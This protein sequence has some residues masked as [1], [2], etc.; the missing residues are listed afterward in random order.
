MKGLLENDDK[1]K[2]C[3][4]AQPIRFCKL[5]SSQVKMEDKPKTPANTQADSRSQ[6][7][8]QFVATPDHSKVTTFGKDESIRMIAGR[9]DG[10]NLGG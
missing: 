2:V 9:V 10:K 1:M 5:I 3:W 7:W 4:Q 8:K 6:P